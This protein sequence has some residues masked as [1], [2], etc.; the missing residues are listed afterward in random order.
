[1]V[2]RTRELVRRDRKR[3]VHLT[4]LALGTRI[5][6]FTARDVRVAL[7]IQGLDLSPSTVGRFLGSLA[8]EGKLLVRFDSSDHRYWRLP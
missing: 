1:M 5:G 4:A 6:E 3:A 2:T 7:S 8:T